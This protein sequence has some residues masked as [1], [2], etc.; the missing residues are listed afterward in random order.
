MQEKSSQNTG[1]SESGKYKPGQVAEEDL[2]LSVI[3]KSGEEIGTINVKSG[4]RIP[5]Y[6]SEDGV[7]EYRKK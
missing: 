7:S 6:R 1:A 2:T 4:E 3:G 5:P